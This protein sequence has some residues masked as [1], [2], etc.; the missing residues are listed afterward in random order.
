MSEAWRKEGGK[1]R[2]DSAESNEDL[3]YI[4]R[5]DNVLLPA[6]QERKPVDKKYTRYKH[7]GIARGRGSFGHAGFVAFVNALVANF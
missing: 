3:L 4:S 1:E 6:S 5:G 2:T 7:T